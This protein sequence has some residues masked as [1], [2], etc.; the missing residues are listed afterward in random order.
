MVHGGGDALSTQSNPDA[1]SLSK[2]AEAIKLKPPRHKK[3]KKPKKQKKHKKA[4][5]GEAAPASTAV[6][7]PPAEWFAPGT[8]SEFFL[9]GFLEIGVQ[10]AFNTVL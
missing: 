9:Y 7:E 3:P 4:K 5:K 1:Q 8:V 6:P 10:I 2:N